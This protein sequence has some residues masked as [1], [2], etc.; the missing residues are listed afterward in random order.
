MAVV[1]ANVAVNVQRTSQFGRSLQP[2]SGQQP[3]PFFRAIV[4]TQG[5]EL[6]PQTADLGNA[7]RPQQ[8]AQLAGR[9]ILQLLDGLEAAQRHVS[10]ED[11]HM[12]GGV[13]AA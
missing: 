10:Q 4:E 3:G 5:G 2:V 13:V 1:E 12:Q 7:V 6:T 11:D 8:F 9:L